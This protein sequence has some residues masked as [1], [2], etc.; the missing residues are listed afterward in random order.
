MILNKVFSEKEFDIEK[1]EKTDFIL[2]NEKSKEKFDVE[3]TELFINQKDEKRYATK[4]DIKN[5]PTVVIY[6]KMQ[7]KN[8]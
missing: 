7:V 2:T 3:I 5:L 8:L 6:T 1:T 4:E